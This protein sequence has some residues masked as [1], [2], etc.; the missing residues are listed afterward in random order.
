M[1]PREAFHLLRTT[2]R[3]E[4][5]TVPLTIGA[6]ALAFGLAAIG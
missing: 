4:L 1:T 2:H 6:I 3:S 5:L